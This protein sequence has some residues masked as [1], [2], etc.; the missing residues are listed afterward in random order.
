MGTSV[1]PD[2]IVGQETLN[3]FPQLLVDDRFV[4]AGIARAV[5]HD[6]A[7][8]D[9][10]LEHVVQRAAGERRAPAVPPEPIHPA[11]A[12][13][14]ALGL[15]FEGPHRANLRVPAIDRAD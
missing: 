3:S 5:V 12:S 10:V 8:V 15:L 6:L 9:A 1:A 2:P 11:L 13:H 4:L 14:D 7:A